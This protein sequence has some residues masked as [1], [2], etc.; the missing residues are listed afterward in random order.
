[1]NI[2]LTHKEVAEL[3]YIRY[4]WCPPREFLATKSTIEHL[5]CDEDYRKVMQEYE[6]LISTHPKF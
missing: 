5:L 3:L 2:E 6:T 1:M 4:G